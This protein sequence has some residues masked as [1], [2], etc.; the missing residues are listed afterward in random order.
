M[1]TVVS[2]YKPKYPSRKIS[3]N[4]ARAKIGKP[5]SVEQHKNRCAVEVEVGGDSMR[6]VLKV[7]VFF[8]ISSYFFLLYPQ[9]IK[10]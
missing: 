7:Q 9:P 10:N 3:V 2:N 8:L 1:G 6:N 5:N 4:K